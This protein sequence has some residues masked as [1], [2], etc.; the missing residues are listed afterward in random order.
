M[1]R[2][3]TSKKLGEGLQAE[4]ATDAKP[5]GRNKLGCPWTPPHSLSVFGAWWRVALVKTRLEVGA[6]ATA[7]QGLVGF[8]P[9]TDGV[10]ACAWRSEG[11]REQELK[12]N[13]CGRPALAPRLG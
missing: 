7:F 10:L 1:S 11:R 5:W 6:G 13:L 12:L 4:A 8:L 9:Q 2:T 3:Q